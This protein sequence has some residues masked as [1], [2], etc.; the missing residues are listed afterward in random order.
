MEGHPDLL[1]VLLRNLVDNA[2]RYSPRGSSVQVHIAHTDDTAS[3]AVSDEG[4][5]IAPNERERIGRRFYRVL[6]TGESGSGLGLSIVRRIAE[7]HLAELRFEQGETGKGLRVIVEF[8]YVP[9]AG[10]AARENAAK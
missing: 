3:V 5:G 2:I 9:Q 6:G 7:I 8:R 10:V 1:F 4:P